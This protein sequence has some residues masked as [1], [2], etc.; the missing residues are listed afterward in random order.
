[1]PRLL[2]FLAS[3]VL[4][5]AIAATS[6]AQSAQPTFAERLGWKSTDRVLI[7][8]VDDAGMSHDSDVGVLK[9]LDAGLATS[10]SVMMPC[11]WVPEVVHY[12][13][14][15]PSA[16]AGLHLTLTSEWKDYRWAPVAGPTVV[17]GLVDS[18]GAMWPSVEE[19]ASHASAD[20]IEA[21]IRAQLARAR[22]MGFQPT[23]LD[24]H[25]GTVYATPAFI[26]RYIKVGAE[27][28]I[29]I[30][31]PG[32]HDTLLAEQYRDE[33]VARLKAEGKWTTA[34]VLP[35]EPGLAQ[36]RIIAEKVWSLGLPVLDDLYNVSY[37]WRLPDGV[38]P[39][40]ANL[41][42]MKVARYTAALHRLKPGVT[43]IIVHATD[44]SEIF[45]FISDS[46]PTRKGDL[47]ALLSP[48]LRE[49]IQREGFILTT[50]RE[51]QQ[52]RDHVA[53]AAK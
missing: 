46:G 7:I 19:T 25:M 52:R 24:T 36:M 37:D 42:Q 4:L 30:M 17:P 34:T 3:T 49:A 23:H 38:P 27:N 22:R 16:D 14:A 1:M 43:Q 33:A 29:P 10:F 28:H 11:P 40:D 21:E 39:T 53:K 18:E 6:H 26:E 50:W 20:E 8:H 15:H 2:R 45:P 32:G 48:E 5:L 51:L 47:L 12:I 44:T 13:H 31:F 35:E 41:R 9:S